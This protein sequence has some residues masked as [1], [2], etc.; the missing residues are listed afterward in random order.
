V[1][2]PDR[3]GP[4]P[5]SAST[6]TPDAG[7]APSFA[8]IIPARNEAETIRRC[9]DAVS[10]ALD[11]AGGMAARPDILVVDNHSTDA[12]VAVVEDTGARVVR[13]P[14][15]VSIA[16]LRNLG[17]ETATADVLVFLD[18]DME[19][20]PDWARSLQAVFAPGNGRADVCGFV[21]D[22]PPDAP[23]FARLWSERLRARRSRDQAVDFL[24]G[25][26]IAVRRPLFQQVGGFSTQ[27]TTSEDKDLVMRLHAAGARVLSLARPNPVHWGYEKTLW[28][29][30]RK[31][32]WR[33]GNHLSMLRRHGVRL[34]LLRFPLISL[35][36]LLWP[37]VCLGLAL[38]FGLWAGVVALSAW[39][40]PA[41]ALTLRFPDSRTGPARVA[42]F[43]VLYWLRFTVAGAAVVSEILG[44]RSRL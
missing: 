30:I 21:E 22:V 18:A 15:R 32:F 34:R 26:N 11:H 9:L 3:H 8:I 28:E 25:R 40:L 10:R 27:L 41:L 7:D 1:S 31:E 14:A 39:W 6:A 23:W 19:V 13:P 42:G 20:P 43:T 24:P 38:G 35:A 4:D 2:A 37:L 29:L 44:R 16:A 5:A 12:T 17:A 33:Q 36:H